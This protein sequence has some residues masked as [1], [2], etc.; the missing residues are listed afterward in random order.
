MTNTLKAA[1]LTLLGSLAL[2]PAGAQTAGNQGVGAADSVIAC[3][4]KTFNPLSDPDWN[5]FFPITIAGIRMGPNSNPPLMYEPAVCYCPSDLFGE[6]LPGIGMTYWQPL[7]VAEIQKIAGC[8]SSLGGKMLL[9]GY[10]NLNSEQAFIGNLKGSPDTS[11]TT[12]MQFHWY[13]Y[14]IFAMLD[15]FT[16]LGCKN[17]GGFNLAY[18]SEVDPYWQNDVW[19][20]IFNPEAGLFGQLTAQFSCMV[21]SIGATAGYPVDALFWCAGTWGGV[22]PMAGTA[23]QSFSTFQVN[24]LIMAK[25]L[26]RQARVGLQWQTIGPAAICSSV[27]NPVWLKS[28]FRVDQVYPIVRKG[29]PMVIGA[30]PILQN[31]VNVTNYPGWDDTVNLIW[32]GQQCCVRF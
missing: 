24:N 28:Q 22:Y 23:N 18:A 8:S 15:L 19:A 4:G 29:K 5:N 14:P 20:G 25:F 30:P 2:G 6:V 11:H 21:D 17:G 10:S 16:D 13:E 27:P 3:H 9:K 31:P 32:Q 7:Y 1:L 26:A 12:R